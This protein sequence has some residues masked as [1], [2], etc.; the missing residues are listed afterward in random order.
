MQVISIGQWWVYYCSC[1][2]G[3]DV[4]SE[5]IGVYVR[6]TKSE[7]GCESGSDG[8]CISVGVGATV[9]VSIIASGS[10]AEWVYWCRCESN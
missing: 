8:E 4:L 6:V 10:N 9:I 1:A 5:Y 7:C 2:N 3:R